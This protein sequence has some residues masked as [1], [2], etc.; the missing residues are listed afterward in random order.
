MPSQKIQR[1]I[2]L[3]AALLK[4]RFPV[5][6][7]ELARDVPGYS[8][9]QSKTALRRTFERD[10]DE[11]RAFGIPI[12]TVT[13]P[14]GETTGYRLQPQHFY[15]PYLTLRSTTGSTKPKKVDRYGYHAL[16]TL[17]F[18]PDQL[19]AVIEAAARVRQLGDPLLAEHAD[20]ALRKL[21]ADLPVD[22]AATPQPNLVPPRT[23]PAPDLLATL[24]HALEMR[25]QVTFSYHGMG[26]PSLRS[27]LA[28]S[29]RARGQA[30]DSRRTVESF[31]LFFL[32]Q[33][34]YLA[35]RTPDD[36][37]VKNYRV[38]RITNLNLN[39]NRPGTPDYDIPAEFNLKEHAGSRHAWEL[40]AGD[41]IDAV[42]H[43]R[44]KSGAAA[45]ALRLG[46]QV[47]GFPDNR[48]FRVRR[49]D[50][51]ARW[52]LS[53]AG[54]IVPVS[55]RSLVDEYRGLVRETLA[56][57]STDRPSDRPPVRL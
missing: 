36:R 38:N 4:R 55:P 40:G 37:T 43:F 1:W 41:A 39:S 52:L 56:H 54:D 3:L 6:L 21:A 44:A 26:D 15:L 7:E 11:L 16:Q 13:G 18:E 53:F 14:E 22:A 27:E 5:P 32:N 2:D 23:K 28:P 20:S 47:Q 42:V 19:S 24:G 50:A 29:H 48:R 9:G 57:H 25:K 8:A 35:G 31:G 51:F 10:K 45:A 33:H 17:A 12:E 46:E 30:K 49:S 34:W